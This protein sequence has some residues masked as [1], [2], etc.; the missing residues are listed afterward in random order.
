[1]RTITLTVL[2]LAAAGPAHAAVA[3]DEK[4]TT[5]PPAVPADPPQQDGVQQW[6]AS[7]RESVMHQCEKAFPGERICGCLTHEIEALSPDPE[8]VT[9]DAIQAGLRRCRKG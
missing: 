4:V 6:T 7:Q 9:S 5:A 3:V 1:M 8:V 2:L